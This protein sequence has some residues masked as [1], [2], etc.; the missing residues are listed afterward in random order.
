MQRKPVSVTV[1]A[2]AV[3]LVAAFFAVSSAL[4]SN[5]IAALVAGIGVVGAASLL[6]ANPRARFVVYIASSLVAL[7]WLALVTQLAIAGWPVPGLVQTIISLVPGLL[8]LVV[9]LGC[10]LL[11]ARY[12]SGHK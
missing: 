3:V 10:A 5:C 7:S 1:L 9:C 4:A 6:S 8:L 11:A 12:S 2:V